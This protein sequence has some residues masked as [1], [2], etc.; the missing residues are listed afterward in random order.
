MV[1][2]AVRVKLKGNTAAYWTTNNPIL[3]DREIA[4][5]TDTKKVKIGDGSTWN[6]T[7]YSGLHDKADIESVLT[8]TITSHTHPGG[9]EVNDLTAIVTWANVPNANITQSSVTQHQASLSIA[10]GQVTG[11]PTTLAGYGITDA[12]PLSH[13]GGN[14][15]IDWSITGPEVIHADR[16]SS[17]G[18]EVNDLTASVTWANIPDA[19]VPQTAVTQHEAALTILESQITGAAF[20]NWNSAFSWGDHALSGY[21]TTALQNKADVEAV[22]TGEIS[23]HTHANVGG[24]DWEV[25]GV[26]VIHPDRYTDTIYTHPAT[27]PWSMIDGRPT[28]LA[29]YGITDAAPLSHVGGNIHIDWSVTGAE[30]VNA[31]RY[32]D[33]V[34]NY[35]DKSITVEAPVSGDDITWFFTNRAITCAELRLVNKESGAGSCVVT[36]RHGTDRNAAGTIV[37]TGTITD[38]TT[39]HDI[40][41]FAD[42][43]IPADSFVW[44]EIGTTS[45]TDEIHGTLIGTID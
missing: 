9:S 12:A 33:T 2:L 42:A 35:W 39:G 15:H 28:T 31:D 11:T 27:H 26:E 23:S 37:Y 13:L 17:T 14:S 19:N 7:P 5:E 16:Y 45:A 21:L 36:I 24:V 1:D 29:G 44:M 3:E 8:G 38:N 25:T 34:Y 30:T 10:W 40:T 43:T 32:T 4:I 22:L 20:A 6:N 41:T 18:S